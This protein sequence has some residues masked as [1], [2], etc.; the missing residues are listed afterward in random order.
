MQPNLELQ[1]AYLNSEKFSRRNFVFM[2][3]EIN[4]TFI[5]GIF[6]DQVAAYL[7]KTTSI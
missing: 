3:D 7:D 1:N 6:R 5:V 4:Y 2:A